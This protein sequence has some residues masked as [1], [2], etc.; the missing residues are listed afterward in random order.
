MR[1]H[2]FCALAIFRLIEQTNPRMIRVFHGHF[3]A[4]GL[5]NNA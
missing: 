4:I 2:N 3:F 5:L 1:G